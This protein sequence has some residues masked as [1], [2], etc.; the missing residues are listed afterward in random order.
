MKIIP[1]KTGLKKKFLKKLKSFVKE[2]FYEIYQNIELVF[3]S[4]S[5][6]REYNRKFAFKTKTTDV[7]SFDID[8]TYVII[9]SVDMAKKNAILYG[10]AF[11]DEVVRYVIHGILH[12]LGFD[13]KIETSFKEMREKEEEMM[14]KWKTYYYY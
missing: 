5:S 2:N 3:V 9:V 8:G 6:M 10:E 14:E 11:E 13:H 12:L 7:L 1:N 4:D